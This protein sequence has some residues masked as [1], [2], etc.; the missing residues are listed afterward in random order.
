MSCVYL[1]I[2]LRK[3]VLLR[4]LKLH[5]HIADFDLRS[6]ALDKTLSDWR[7]SV[8]KVEVQIALRNKNV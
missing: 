3:K 6:M 2:A 1:F 7:C 5:F 4:L 8:S